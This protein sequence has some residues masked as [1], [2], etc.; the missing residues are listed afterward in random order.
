MVCYPILVAERPP[1][2]AEK[3]AEGSGRDRKTVFYPH[4]LRKIGRQREEEY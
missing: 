4:L 1:E 2:L 3:K